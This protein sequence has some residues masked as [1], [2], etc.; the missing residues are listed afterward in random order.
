MVSP[1]T[2]LMFNPTGPIPNATLIPPA[3]KGHK[4]SFLTK[5]T[6][7]TNFIIHFCTMEEICVG[8][9]H[10]YPLRGIPRDKG[11]TT[12][13]DIPEGLGL[14]PGETITFPP[15]TGRVY[16][17]IMRDNHNR[18]YYVHNDTPDA[19]VVRD[20]VRFSGNT[21]I[22]SLGPGRPLAFAEGTHPENHDSLFA[23]R[24]V[25]G[26]TPECT[27]P[28]TI[29]WQIRC[30][31]CY[32]IPP[33][34]LWW[35]LC[36]V[37]NLKVKEMGS[38]TVIPTPGSFVITT[39]RTFVTHWKRACAT[40][41][42]VTDRIGTRPATEQERAQL[43]EI[44]FTPGIQTIRDVE[45]DPHELSIEDTRYV[46]YV[47]DIATYKK[48]WILQGT[49]H[50]GKAF[51]RTIDGYETDLDLP[52]AA[53]I[54]LPNARCARYGAVVKHATVG[55]HMSW[56]LAH[57]GYFNVRAAALH[58]H[59]MNFLG[60]SHAHR[61]SDI[62][63]RCMYKRPRHGTTNAL[64]T[65][66]L[67]MLPH[68][69]PK[70]PC[71]LAVENGWLK[72]TNSI[73]TLPQ[74]YPIRRGAY[75]IRSHTR[76]LSADCMCCGCGVI[77][78]ASQADS[79][80]KPHP[81]PCFVQLCCA[82]ARLTHISNLSIYNACVRAYNNATARSAPTLTAI[83]S[84][85]NG[86][87]ILAHFA[88]AFCYDCERAEF[89]TF[90]S[91]LDSYCAED[92]EVGNKSDD[93][94][95]A[96]STNATTLPQPYTPLHYQDDELVALC[97]DAEL[98]YNTPSHSF[99]T[100]Q[101]KMLLTIHHASGEVTMT[102]TPRRACTPPEDCQS[103]CWE[104]A[105]ARAFTQ[106]GSEAWWDMALYRYPVRRL[107]VVVFTQYTQ[108]PLQSIVWPQCTVQCMHIPSGEHEPALEIVGTHAY[109]YGIPIA[110]GVSPAVRSA[111][112]DGNVKC[113]DFHQV[114]AACN[115]HVLRRII[116]RVLEAN[117]I[118]PAIVLTGKEMYD[119]LGAALAAE[120]PWYD[121]T[122]CH[123]ADLIVWVLDEHPSAVGA[124]IINVVVLLRDPDIYTLFCKWIHLYTPH[125][126]FIL[127]HIF[128]FTD[129]IFKSEDKTKG[130]SKVAA[131]RL[132]N[133]AYQLDPM[134]WRRTP[135]IEVLRKR[136]M[137]LCDRSA[138]KR[139][140][141]SCVV[142]YGAEPHEDTEDAAN[143]PL[144]LTSCQHVVCITCFQTL[145]ALPHPSCPICRAAI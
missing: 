100:I 102:L 32:Y 48:K 50:D 40:H 66:S 130:I 115:H 17:F 129:H 69:P 72:T 16:F 136:I 74:Y 134:V 143:S 113:L 126:S 84:A 89:R 104:R 80:I 59:V 24:Y 88:E 137:W 109:L 41:V 131:T 71:M 49:A 37:D 7:H 62:I 78:S 68:V 112:A 43:N 106:L 67:E 108:Q 121:P 87:S 116:A 139:N 75:L 2:P 135:M 22:L 64:L 93:E 58:K 27:P 132:Q 18:L 65:A 142:C 96:S 10:A 29:R 28:V 79:T 119:R 103:V 128:V 63:M 13:K 11:A 90:L 54:L 46:E 140:T 61:L 117:V 144:M 91:S 3:P 60:I 6:P 122:N 76:V 95:H 133:P 98:Y 9:H 138:S 94:A 34:M 23:Y 125:Q 12:W 47:R 26:A 44:P 99:T 81:T 57:C 82:A 42:R 14:E 35:T 70:S 33:I 51:L 38:M 101:D 85:L 20:M 15:N 77:R 141:H 30:N 86:Y 31:N 92:V 1:V 21:A 45:P 111:L 56:D 39:T 8:P 97:H 107:A 105:Y 123:L 83:S 4:H 118:V 145:S 53:R 124:P 25:R 127:E 19:S 110:D 73:R 5:G 36:R 52:V 55:N 120:T 114:R